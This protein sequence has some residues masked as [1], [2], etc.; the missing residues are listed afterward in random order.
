MTRQNTSSVKDVEKKILAAELAY[1]GQKKLRELDTLGA[2]KDYSLSKKYG[3]DFSGT[4][5]EQYEE[6]LKITKELREWGQRYK[7]SKSGSLSREEE[8]NILESYRRIKGV[9]VIGSVELKVKQ[10]TAELEGE[11]S[12]V[13][14]A[15]NCDTDLLL[16]YINQ[17]RYQFSFTQSMINTLTQYKS[18]QS[19]ISTLKSDVENARTVRSAYFSIDS[20]VKSVEELPQDVKSS[21]ELCI[22]NDRTKTFEGYADQARKTGN[23]SAARKFDSIA[24]GKENARDEE[25]SSAC[26]GILVFNKG[27]IVIREKLEACKPEDARKVWN[28]IVFQLADCEEKAVIL[29]SYQSLADSIAAMQ[30]GESVFNNYKADALKL[31]QKRRYKDAREKYAQMADLE[32]CN[33]AERDLEIEKGLGEIKS[34]EIKPMFRV[35]ISGGGGTNYPVYKIANSDVKMSYGLVTSGGIDISFIDHHNPVDL[36]AGV[37]YLHT[38]YEALNNEGFAKEGYKLDGVSLSLVIKIHPSNTNPDKIRPYIKI[39][40]EEIIPVSYQY[41]NYATSVTKR[42]KGPLNTL[43]SSIQ[44]GFGLEMQKKDFGF[45]VEGIVNYGLNGIYDNRPSSLAASGNQQ[46]EA[47]FRRVGLKVGLRFW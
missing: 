5:K 1:N 33:A 30:S 39:G 44:G 24:Q 6:G 40:R 41:D 35:G 25:V 47:K 36:V 45:F 32:V 19:K 43:V 29:Q 27:V 9:P 17:N 37:E 26:A 34:K 18:I 7:S 38:Q 23:M 2:L 16:N 46:I 42:D 8:K 22:K 4:L 11:N 3:G 14:F 31:L 28:E 13:S 12:M 15:R 10:I 20:M 21:L